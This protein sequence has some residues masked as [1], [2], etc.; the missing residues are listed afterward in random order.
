MR[1]IGRLS[2]IGRDPE[3]YK[4]QG[5]LM[6]EYYKTHTPW[7]TGKTHTQEA[8]E[9]N[10]LAH[11]GRVRVCKDNIVKNVPPDEV[12]SY[13]S[14]GWQIMKKE[15]KPL[16]DIIFITNGVVNKKIHLNELKEWE[17]KGFRRGC[18]QNRYKQ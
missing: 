9:K 7:W 3:S 11:L 16:T 5:R 17:A 12:D 6:H 2:N 15:Y 14:D 10:R 18:M 1:E 13:L 4:K 8:K